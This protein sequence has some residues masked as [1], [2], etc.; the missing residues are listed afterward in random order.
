MCFTWLGNRYLTFR[1][2]AGAAAC[3]RVPGMA[4]IHGRQPGGRG[5]SITAS[6]CC[7][8]ISPPPPFNNKYVAQACGVL[9]GLVFNFTLSRR[10]CS[11]RRRV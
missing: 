8:C 9:A 5:W 6:R 2:R 11:K 7:W 4:E 1:E 10:W 3:R